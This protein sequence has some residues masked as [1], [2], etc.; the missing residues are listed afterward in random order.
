MVQQSNTIE[1]FCCYARKDGD[2]LHELKTH[3]SPLQ[4][5]KTIH[6]WHDGDISAGTEWGQEIK[7]HL[8][9]AEIILLLISS[10]FIYSEYCY[11][12]EMKRA[13]E[14][15][16][17]REAKVIPVLLRPLSNWEK[18]P[19]GDIHLGQ[20]QAL[21]KNAKPVTSWA[22]IDEA[23][24]EVAE[25]IERVINEL[26]RE[27]LMPQSTLPSSPF[28]SVSIQ[29]RVDQLP[30]VPNSEAIIPA[31]SVQQKLRLPTEFYS[32]FISCS[33]YDRDIAERLYTDLQSKGVRCWFAPHHMKIGDKIRPRID[34]S[35]RTY[36]KL[37]LIL[38]KHSVTSPWV[39]TEVEAAFERERQQNKLVLFPVRIDETVMQTT[40]VWAAEIRRARHIGDF[41]HWKDQNSYE[42]AL[43]CLLRDLKVEPFS[44]N[45]ESIDAQN[46][47]TSHKH[48]PPISRRVAIV[49]GLGLLSAMT[50][51]GCLIWR[52]WS[53]SPPS[54]LAQKVTP[55]QGYPDAKKE[56]QYVEGLLEPRSSFSLTALKNGMALLV[57]GQ[58]VGGGYVD[59]GRLF[60]PTT[61]TWE[62]TSPP[63]L[64]RTEHTATLLL[65]GKVLIA[66]GYNGQAFLKSA[67]L[68]DP[69][70]NTW[71]PTG[72]MNQ[73]R[74]HHGAVR[75]SNGDVLVAGGWAGASPLTSTEIYHHQDGT[76]SAVDQPL[77]TGRLVPTCLLLPDGTVLVAGGVG[78]NPVG[79]T[80]VELFDPGTQSWLH[81]NE[82]SIARASLGMVWLPSLKK[83]LCIGGATANRLLNI[84]ELYDPA[85]NQWSS[86]SP[87]HNG[88]ALNTNN[89]GIP[90]KD[91]KILVVGNDDLGTSEIYNPTTRQWS[92]PVLIGQPHCQGP[93]VL[94][95][96]G[97]VLIVG[98]DYAFLYTQK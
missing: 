42:Q 6:V 58:Y 46:R 7:Q 53:Q 50:I 70:T 4:R 49:G 75:L 33:S 57:G 79:L 95:K 8:N 93:S 12:S 80:G 37:L 38:S 16:K 14:R 72:S 67:E 90:L 97:Q 63:H 61:G 76:W 27:S 92:E 5:Q 82:M 52:T 2:L 35:I 96:D 98:N 32:C 31:A 60:H 87:M 40:Q 88:R 73:D 45:I 21:P 77:L 29:K 84:V 43:I 41:T 68:Y 65:D 1:I 18:V 54:S 85:T 66:G 36:D 17:R 47:P 9:N 15:H 24:K 62:V 28:A 74:T 22:N 11:G 55:P 13:L 81:K 91:G 23:W 48:R 25:G 83:V 34:E 39:E 51:G 78:S 89:N 10:D 86:T 64:G 30:S 94:L 3:L 69:S 44:G 26:L 59:E 19:P 56:W 71:L 20:L